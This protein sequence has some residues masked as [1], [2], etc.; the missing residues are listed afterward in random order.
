MTDVEHRAAAV[1][2][3]ADWK[4]RGDEKPEQAVRPAGVFPL[5]RGCEGPLVTGICSVTICNSIGQ[6]MSAVPSSICSPS[7]Q[8][9]CTESGITVNTDWQWKG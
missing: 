9:N 1:R 3:A 4:D 8:S 7:I 6:W 5:R 2:F